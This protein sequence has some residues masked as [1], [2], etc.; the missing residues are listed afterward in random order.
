MSKLTLL[1]PWRVFNLFSMLGKRETRCPS[2]V[3]DG[4]IPSGRTPDPAL[5]GFEGHQCL[6][7]VPCGH[8]SSDSI[9]YQSLA[10]KH[11]SNAEEN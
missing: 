7:P 3:Q 11:Q 6:V 9:L 8:I 4:G 5:A 1:G 10:I 2:E